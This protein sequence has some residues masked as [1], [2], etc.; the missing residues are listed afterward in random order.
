[1]AHVH[2]FGVMAPEAAG[3]IQYATSP[4]V[5]DSADPQSRSYFMLRYRVSWSFLSEEIELIVVTPT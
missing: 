3:I 4:T 1:M 5:V 2:T